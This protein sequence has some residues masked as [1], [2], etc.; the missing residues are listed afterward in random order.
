MAR[1]FIDKPKKA[2]GNRGFLGFGI[3]PTGELE[4]RQDC[5][6]VCAYRLLIVPTGE[7]EGRQDNSDWLGPLVVIVPTG[8][9]EGRQD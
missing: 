2:P 7:L 1:F 6:G 5:F 4:G 8:E 3:V 9:L